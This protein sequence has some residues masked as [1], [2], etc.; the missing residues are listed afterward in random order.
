MTASRII[1]GHG[2]RAT[3]AL[4]LRHL[5]D[6]LADTQGDLSLLS[7]PVR[8]IVPSISLRNHLAA[9]IV[10][11]FGRSVAGCQVLTLFHGVL[12]LLERSGRPA[13]RGAAL[14][15]VLV[16]R[17]ARREPPLRDRLEELVDGYGVVAGTVRDFLDAGFEPVHADALDELLRS[18]A[19]AFATPAEVERALALLRTTVAT[20]EALAELG[21]GHRSAMLREAQEALEI[22]GPELLPTRALLIHGFADATGVATDL[23]ESLLRRFGGT[24]YLDHPPTQTAGV[25]ETAF[26]AHFAGRLTQLAPLEEA[27]RPAVPDAALQLVEAPEPDAELREVAQRIRGLLASGCEPESIGVVARDLEPYA[28]GVRRQFRALGIPFSAVGAAGPLSPAGRDLAAVSELLRRGPALPLERW[29]DTLRFPEAE[30]RRDLRSDLRL[31]LFSLGASRLE[32]SPRLDIDD[33]QELRLPLR[34]GLQSAEFP[35]GEPR[36][37]AVHRKLSPTLVAWTANAAGGLCREL[38]AW[39]DCRSWPLERHRETLLRVL[40]Q[41]LGWPPEL[42]ARRLIDDQ[43][44][45][46]I[47]DA[48][49]QLE[50]AYDEL[51]LMVVEVL[52]GLDAVPLGGRGGGVQVLTAMEARGRSFEHLFLFALNRD[53]FP[54]PVHEDA[55]LPDRLRSGIAKLLPDLPIKARGFDEERYLLAQ[56]LSAAPRV[57]VSWHRHDATGERLAPSPLVDRLRQGE[58]VE[59]VARIPHLLAISPAGERPLRPIG[60]ELLVSALHGGRAAF[61][62]LLPLAVEEVRRSFSDHSG[63]VAGGVAGAVARGRL[64][65]LEELD[66]DRSSRD[67]AARSALVGPYFGFVGPLGDPAD[68]RLSDLYIT[69][70]ENLAACPWQTFLRR[71][72]RLRPMPDPLASLPSFRGLLVGSLV[73]RVLERIASEGLAARRSDAAVGVAWPDPPALEALL[74]EEAERVL[75]ERGLGLKGLGRAAVEQARPY[76]EAARQQDWPSAAGPA[77][78]RVEAIDALRLRDEGSGRE[79]PIRFRADR[80]D[81]TGED[82]RLHTDYKTGAPPRARKQLRKS[83]LEWVAGGEWLQAAA[84]V[85]GAGAGSQGRYLFLRPDLAPESRAICVSADDRELRSVFEDSLRVLLRAW[86]E[87]AFFPRL[88]EPDQDLEPPRCRS[89]EVAEACLR[90]DSGARAR[91][92]RWTEAR[93]EEGI[94]TPSGSAAAL[95]GVWNLRR[96]DR[97]EESPG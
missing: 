1:I 21:L 60:E 57:M 31:A 80:V 15:A 42:P 70:L 59:S 94:R 16:R 86:D 39:R 33:A 73:H 8:V 69:T 92:R 10:R 74:A 52:R 27:G 45:E 44:A 63:D 2:A 56:L 87:G 11:R 76:L 67:G 12:E 48:P 6:L 13:R 61:A 62:A 84:Y 65:V 9:A 51:V 77:V 53:V 28:P 83:L 71:L 89:C 54:R 38:E 82:L 7:R 91:L 18:E 79:R 40:D 50:L 36:G 85:H 75:Q 3:E 55:L 90:R 22:A 64:A 14:V 78:L 35:D 68:P 19:R 72:L 29:L 23:I 49:P 32:D 88:V 25:D 47:R 26:T 41:H 5:E 97:D 66:P 43:L 96:K 34:D 37:F 20:Q 24:L 93:Q 95:L 30:L 4:V 81:V 46:L 17:F 58:R